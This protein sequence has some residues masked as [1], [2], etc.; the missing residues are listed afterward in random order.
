MNNDTARV[1]VVVVNYNCQEVLLKSLQCIH[2]Q[3]RPA[4]RVIVIDNGSTDGF[5]QIAMRQFPD[6]EFRF[7]PD[8]KGFAAAN[9]EAVALASD[10]ELVALVNPD[11]Y[12]APDWLETMLA[13]A[14]A[15]PGCASFA[16]QLRIAARPDFLDGIGDAFHLC[17][18]AWR[19]GHGK[20]ADA[21]SAVGK[22]VFSACAAAA[23]YRRE[24]FLQVG[25]FDEQFF[26]YVE[27]VD[28]GFR[29]RLA[30]HVCRYIPQAR[31]QHVGSKSSGGAH[32]EFAVF[33]GHRNISWCWFK[34]MPGPLLLLSLPLH[35]LSWM[36]IFGVHVRRGKARCVLR[37]KLGAL[38]GLP[39]IWRSRQVVMKSRRVSTQ[40]IWRVLDK[41]LLPFR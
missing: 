8:N 5:A 12:L 25:G 38:K 20:H 24:A 11:A 18:L 7:L 2:E 21:M 15:Y 28:L 33:H 13:A 37:A 32:S 35:L 40:Q 31:A 9:N 16:S 36:L 29:L 4:H 6:F 41:R 1:A 10:C 3:S 23:L 26:C 30:G 27:D 19:V 17:G 22:E 14:D 39:R 34:N